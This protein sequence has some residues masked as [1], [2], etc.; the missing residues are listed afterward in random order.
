M[1]AWVFILV[2]FRW[3]PSGRWQPGTLARGLLGTGG[4]R[5]RLITEWDPSLTLTFFL[6]LFCFMFYVY[7][8]PCGLWHSTYKNLARLGAPSCSFLHQQ[9]SLLLMIGTVGPLNFTDWYPI[10]FFRSKWQVSSYI[11]AVRKY[12]SV[13]AGPGACDACSLGAQPVATASSSDWWKTDE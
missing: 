10:V 6:F 7:M 2:R 12:T 4:L 11:L 13:G 1:C 9:L 3:G 8:Q 5:Y